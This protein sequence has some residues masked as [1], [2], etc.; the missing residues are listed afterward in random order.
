MLAALHANASAFKKRAEKNSGLRKAETCFL[1][2]LSILEEH[3]EAADGRIQSALRGM[4]RVYLDCGDF[5]RAEPL[6]RRLLSICEKIYGADA[7][8]LLWILIELSFGYAHEGSAEAE[9]MMER[10]FDVLRTFL[11]AKRPVLRSEIGELPGSK[12]VLFAGIGEGL[13]EKL[14]R[15]SEA[16]RRN[17]R[18]RWGA[19]G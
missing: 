11:D 12:E 14:V 10:S 19:S 7:A 1:Q 3:F 15:A 6:L 9:P 2:G 13:L 5:W 4:A 8:A 17:T 16:A 18:M